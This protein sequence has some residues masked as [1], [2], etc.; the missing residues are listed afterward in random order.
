LDGRRTSGDE[1]VMM[2]ERKAGKIHSALTA[3]MA[4]ALA[5]TSDR[6]NDEAANSRGKWDFRSG[7]EAGRISY[8]ALRKGAHS[9]AQ[10][11]GHEARG[12]R[13]PTALPPRRDGLT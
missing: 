11:V 8:G 3:A 12:P 4:R 6:D 9:P 2:R 5:T 13:G 7:R 1:N 10:A